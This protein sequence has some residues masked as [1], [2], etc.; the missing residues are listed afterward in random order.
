MSLDLDRY[1]DNCEHKTGDNW[2]PNGARKDNQACKNWDPAEESRVTL[3][4]HVQRL[5]ICKKKS[6]E[7]GFVMA[8]L[9]TMCSAACSQL[10]DMKPEFERLRGMCEEALRLQWSRNAEKEDKS[11]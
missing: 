8:Q 4:N 5:L 11:L 7:C 2:C 3:T 1:C 6:Y 9:Y 10:P